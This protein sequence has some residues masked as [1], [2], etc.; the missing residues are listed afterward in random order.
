[1]EVA[2]CSG[3]CVSKRSLKINL[4]MEIN[5]RVCLCLCDALCV[6]AVDILKHWTVFA[7]A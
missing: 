3:K 1:V 4:N 7:F 5:S 6:V 2:S